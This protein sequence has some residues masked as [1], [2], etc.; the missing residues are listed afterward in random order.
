MN[1][2]ESSEEVS[3]APEI[4]E[5]AEISQ[6]ESS[7]DVPAEDSKLRE[8]LESGVE[9]FELREEFI[10]PE[11]ISNKKEGACTECEDALAVVHCRECDEIY[12]RVCFSGLHR[13]GN[14]LNHSTTKIRDE[15][16]PSKPMKEEISLK[17]EQMEIDDQKS[18]D[19]SSEDSSED[20]SQNLPEYV[21]RAKYIP[22]RLQFK[23]R[24]LLRLLEGVLNASSYTDKSDV[25]TFQ[26]KA[27]RTYTQLVEICSSLSGLV[28]AADYAEGQKI[29]NDRSFKVHSDFFQLIFEI[30]RRHKI[31]NPEKMRSEYGKLMYMLQDSVSPEVKELLEFSCVRPIVTV[32]E[33]LKSHKVEKLLEHPKIEIATRAISTHDLDGRKKSRQVIR[34]EVRQKE[35]AVEEISRMYSN[36]YGGLSRDDIKW[37]LYSIG[38]NRSFLLTTRDPVEK[39]IRLLKKYF[40]PDHFE[41]GYS[42]AIEGG[43]DGARLTHA[44]DRQYYYCLQSL[45]LWREVTNEMFKLWYL[46]DTDLLT[47][48][49]SYLLKDTGQGVHRVQQAPNIEKSMRNILHTVQQQVGHWVGSSVIHLGDHNVPNA[50]MFID[51]YTQVSR[52]LNPITITLERIDDLML[53]PHINYFIEHIFNGADTLKKDILVDFFKYA[54]DGSGADNFFDAG[55]CIDG[56]LT[57]AWNWC[58]KLHEK[59]FYSIFKLTGFTGFDGEFQT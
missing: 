21:E 2:E 28:V 11:A 50:L 1:N 59:P 8:L 16:I 14:R 10:A 26:N 12:C 9:H 35:T 41:A 51:K 13:K 48:E 46:A 38:D 20:S 39:M 44:H 30:G 17:T 45:T 58:S 36:S 42:L 52:I 47:P 55:S 43:R 49:V 53:D 56:R 54:F 37:A 7:E 15:P 25:L 5:E 6:E 33:Y 27:R 18:A 23:E 57:S 24:K 22:I 4:S 31:M 19:E 3:S 32:Y 34:D 29:V 40:S